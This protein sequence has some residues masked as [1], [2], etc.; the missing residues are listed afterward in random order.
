MLEGEPE[1]KSFQALRHGCVSRRKGYRLQTQ[2]RTRESFF[3]T[4]SLNCTEPRAGFGSE[5]LRGCYALA[6]APG[7]TFFHSLA[8]AAEGEG[9]GGNVIR[10]ARTGSNVRS[11]ADAH[12]RYQ[13]GI[14][15]DEISVFDDGDVLLLSVVVAGDGAR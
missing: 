12:R 14:A 6:P 13:S 5:L 10:D 3:N 4:S 7:P 1:L 15:A 11:F 2:Q 9:V 8:S